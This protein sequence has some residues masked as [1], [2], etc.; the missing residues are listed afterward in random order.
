M[1]S[2]PEQLQFDFDTPRWSWLKNINQ[3]FE[4]VEIGQIEGIDAARLKQKEE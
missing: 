1:M 4:V 3:E 2:E